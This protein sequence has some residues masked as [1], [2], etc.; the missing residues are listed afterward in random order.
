MIIKALIADDEAAA[1]S[2]LRKLLAD[3]PDVHIEA[4]A[5]DGV[6]TLEAI[7]RHNP[8]VLF[9]DVQM[10][11]LTG[12]EVVQAL[13]AKRC[14]LIVFVTAYDEYALAAFEADALAY[15]LKPV[16]QPRLQTAMQ[17]VKQI[18]NSPGE[19]ASEHARLQ[20]AAQAHREPLR[21][22]VAVQR[23][24]YLILPL[25]DVCFFRVEDGI[26]RVKTVSANYRTHYAIGD[27]EA[28]L[29]FPPFFRAH[30]SIIANMKMVASVAPMFRGSLLLTMKDDQHSEIQVSERQARLVR[31]V[32]QL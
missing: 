7:E 1:R 23:D 31:E 21:H 17:R 11:G 19:T 4:E 25:D 32:L 16:A 30:R 14:P 24:R 27:L 22:V 6:A 8:D 29:P 28:R 13:P 9:L 2:R 12:F 20:A 3:Y 15:L 26:T 18:L 5:D 10:P